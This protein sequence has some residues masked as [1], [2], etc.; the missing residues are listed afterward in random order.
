MGAVFDENSTGHA[1]LELYGSDKQLSTINP[2][3]TVLLSECIAI[4]IVTFELCVP[5]NES[6]SSF[7]ENERVIQIQQRAAPVMLIT[8][9]DIEKWHSILCKIAFPNQASFH[10]PSAF[11]FLMVVAHLRMFSVYELHTSAKLYAGYH[12]GA[13]QDSNFFFVAIGTQP[14]SSLSPCSSGD[15]AIPADVRRIPVVLQRISGT[16]RPQLPEGNYDMYLNQSLVV[17]NG[18]HSV[19]W[20]YIQITWFATGYNCF[21]FEIAKEGRYEFS[22]SQPM[23]PLH[24]LR[25]HTNLKNIGTPPR[26]VTKNHYDYYFVPS[27]VITHSP[28]SNSCAN[29]IQEKHHDTPYSQAE[30][31]ELL[32]ATGYETHLGQSDTESRRLSKLPFF[33]RRHLNN[34]HWHERS[35]FEMNAD[36]EWIRCA[37]V[38]NS[39]WV[40]NEDVNR[41]TGWKRSQNEVH[42]SKPME[43]EVN[44]GDL[45]ASNKVVFAMLKS[46]Q[47]DRE[48]NISGLCS[49]FVAVGCRCEEEVCTQSLR[50]FSS[51]VEWPCALAQQTFLH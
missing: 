35:D 42:I 33:H 14:C 1:R 51:P 25:C 29:V 44:L 41:K 45:V 9:E 27:T 5:S 24:A 16:A 7:A 11:K 6:R 49:L 22:S 43:L 39:L 8:V 50:G 4:R 36:E 46:I 48:C 2:A 30:T 21:A 26:F 10:S 37:Y 19:A 28:V 38:R 17:S 32:I 20:E 12:G 13:S 31:S 15:Y 47:L 34:N 18:V 23:V 3:K 40:N